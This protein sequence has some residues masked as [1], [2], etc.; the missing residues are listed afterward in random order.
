MLSNYSAD[1]ALKRM[2]REVR[3]AKRAIGD[4]LLKDWSGSTLCC[5]LVLQYL[6]NNSEDHS[7]FRDA[8]TKLDQFVQ[9]LEQAASV[10]LRFTRTQD[11]Y[12]ETIG[13]LRLSRQV[14]T[15]LDEI[16]YVAEHQGRQQLQE[17]FDNN[18]LFFQYQ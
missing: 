11:I 12:M 7:L 10:F 8:S 2:I 18:S 17:E 5:R 6:H 14:E 1:H 3:R 9:R 15:G 13:L 4:M 16:C